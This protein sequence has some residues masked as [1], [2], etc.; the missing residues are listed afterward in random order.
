M[1]A[2]AI[3]LVQ[4]PGGV[5]VGVRDWLSANHIFLQGASGKVIIDTGYLGHAATTRAYVEAAFG[6]FALDLIV[7]T[8]AHSDHMGCN[9]FLQRWTHA[10]IAVPAGEAEAILKWDERALWLSY[11]DQQ[12]ER[13]TPQVLLHAGQM[14]EWGDI[15]WQAISAPGHDDGT[16][17]FYNAQHCIL[18]SADALWQNGFGTIFPQA[19]DASVI[20]RTR[21][22]LESIA[23]LDID[24]VIPGHGAPF[25]DVSEALRNAHSRLDAF[26]A[27][28]LRAARSMV[29]VM[30]IYSVLAR[31]K[32]PLAT[33]AQYVQSV[34]CLREFN[35]QFLRMS[36]VAFSDWLLGQAI[37]TGSARI[38]AGE[39][40]ASK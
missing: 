3:N 28:D 24:W 21:A 37:S 26:A 7:N 9:A 15:A 4:L 23:A 16:L 18:I 1:T 35:D 40:I 29:R 6:E 17:I 34:P 5:R 39:L 27:D 32:L 12:C 20:S 33:M 30:F 22:S 14:Y 36:P 8:H 13:F 10:P 19:V 11:A 25:Q 38:E 2:P 31:G